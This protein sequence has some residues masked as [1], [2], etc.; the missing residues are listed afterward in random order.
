MTDTSPGAGP[1]V[2]TTSDTASLHAL[3]IAC[4]VLFLLAGVNGITAIIG[5]VLA[6]LKRSDARGTIWESHFRNVIVVFWAM[7]IAGLIW[8]FSFPV[9]F[10]FLWAQ[11]FVWPFVPVLG[12]PL[13]LWL[14]AGPILVIWY[15]YRLIRGLIRLLDDKPY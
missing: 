10:G 1:T 4:Y 14:I 12:A 7:L 15:F 6:Y 9:S 11:D 13:V 2:P 3:A 5:V 8:L